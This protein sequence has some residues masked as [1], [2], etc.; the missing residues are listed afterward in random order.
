MRNLI[1]SLSFVLFLV[2]CEKEDN[3]INQSAT[4]Q[5]VTSFKDYYKFI[6][7]DTNGQLL[8]QSTTSL[9]SENSIYNM[10]SMKKGN[11]KSPL[12]LRF[13]NRNFGNDKTYITARSSNATSSN[14]DLSG[15]F[16]KKITFE[17][18][19]NS[20]TARTTS[21]TLKSSN[22]AS[23]IYIPEL[24]KSKVNGL[25]NGKVVEGTT[26]TWNADSQNSNGVILTMEY[27][28]LTQKEQSLALK[29]PK[30]I[31]RGSTMEDTGVYTITASDL[32]GFPD[33]SSISF[34]IGRVGY[35]VVNDKTADEDVSVG[36]ITA[37]RTDFYIKK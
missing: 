22:S 15:F 26:I 13:D 31:T 30:D 20:I 33:N 28:T 16:G 17:L 11:G 1:L 3:T 27:K 19:N 34:F 25:V 32:S 5:K 37:V 6:N 7:A 35:G 24:I 18:K 21:S 10:S 2:S 36:G 8:I 4:A 9:K 12:T 23:D 14:A 29:F